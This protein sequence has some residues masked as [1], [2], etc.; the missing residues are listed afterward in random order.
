MR[1]GLIAA[2]AGR[3]ATSFEDGARAGARFGVV[4]ADAIRFFPE[5]VS[6]LAGEVESLLRRARIDPAV[7]SNRHSVL[8]YRALIRLLEITATELKC[9]AVGLRLAALQGGTRAMGPIGVAMKNS[10]TLGQALGYCARQIHAYSLATQVRFVPDRPRHKLFVA[11]EILVDRVPVKSQSIEHALLLANLNIQ[12]ITGGAA[13]ARQVYFSHAPLSA[14]GVYRAAF[15]CEVLFGQSADGIVLEERDLLCPVAGADE[16]LYEMATAYIED[17]YPSGTPPLHARVR[18]LIQ[19]Y[20]G[21][22]DCTNERIAAQLC[23][24]PRTLQRRL[25]LEGMTFEIIKDDARR[26]AALRYLQR[27]EMALTQVAEKLGYS[28]QSVLS[29]SCY[30]WFSASPREMRERALAEWA[31][32]VAP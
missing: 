1:A 2:G 9:P 31:H 27:P 11:L 13:Q 6:G 20:L 10:K 24:H 4:H 12:D 21:H 3:L 32:P 26:E 14:P 22:E 17:Q 16:R 23:L 29:R 8:E 28:E 18:V 30:R 15:G 5:L 7:C 19:R 25:K